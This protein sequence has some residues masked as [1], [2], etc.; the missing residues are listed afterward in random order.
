MSDP[1]VVPLSPDGFVVKRDVS[2][3]C[4]GKDD[5][6]R[7]L[8][9]V[10]PPCRACTRHAAVMGDVCHCN[11]ELN[12]DAGRDP[13]DASDAETASASC[14][15]TA[16]TSMPTLPFR[17]VS[18]GYT[19]EVKVGSSTTKKRKS[20]SSSSKKSGSIKNKKSSKHEEPARK[21]RKTQVN[22]YLSFPLQ[23]G[24]CDD[25]VCK[26]S[27]TVPAE[28]SKRARN[29][30]IRDALLDEI[31]AHYECDKDAQLK[32]LGSADFVKFILDP[33][34]NSGDSNWSETIA[35]MALVWESADACAKPLGRVA[36]LSM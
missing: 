31:Y 22:V 33:V 21:K 13:Y 32:N 27:V 1:I 5:P 30:L 11:S 8:L 35:Q 18:R 9:S 26:I 20:S 17:P 15:G 4:T 28:A 6:E 14:S 12:D 29:R 34:N 2:V 24:D 19:A 16:S 10:A 25:G 7:E 36:A 23:D 3:D